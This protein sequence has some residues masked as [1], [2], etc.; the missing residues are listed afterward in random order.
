MNE[1]ARLVIRGI[2]SELYYEIIRNQFMVEAPWNSN[3]VYDVI[4]TKIIRKKLEKYEEM[5]KE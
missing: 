3:E 5:L 2:L 4:D 1:I